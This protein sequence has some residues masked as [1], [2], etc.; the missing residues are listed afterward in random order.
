MADE[1]QNILNAKDILFVVAC[2]ITVTGFSFSARM[3]ACAARIKMMM[4]RAEH[5][6]GKRLLMHKRAQLY[7][8]IYIHIYVCIY[9][10]V[11]HS[12][13]VSAYVWVCVCGCV[14]IGVRGCVCVGFAA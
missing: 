4:V 14:C 6:R 3:P 13:Q 11:T 12:S 8:Y 10:F 2:Q 1:L 7:F 9:A 5:H